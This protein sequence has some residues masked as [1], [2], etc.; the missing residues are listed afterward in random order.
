MPTNVKTYDGTGDPE[1]HLKIFQTAAKIERKHSL[2]T[3][4]DKRNTSR[5]PW[6]YTTSNKGNE[7][8]RKPSWSASKQKACMSTGLQSA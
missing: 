8:Q 5:I 3:S 2:E 6:K 7:S 4:R 1:D